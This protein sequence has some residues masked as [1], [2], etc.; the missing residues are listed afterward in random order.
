MSEL[1]CEV[2]KDLLPSYADGITDDKTSELVKE[3]LASC[4]PC[5]IALE[6][7]RENEEEPSEKET[8][9][10]DFLKKSRRKGIKIAVIAACCAALIALAAVLIKLFVIGR[11][12][13]YENLSVSIDV[14][15]KTLSVTGEAL[16]SNRAVSGIKFTEKDG[17]VAV[18]A[19]T[20]VKSLLHN[21]EAKGEYVSENTI[22]KVSVNGKTVYEN[23]EFTLTFSDEM[24]NAGKE[25]WEHY[26]SLPEIERMLMSTSPG[27]MSRYFGSWQEAAEY[28]GFEIAE[29]LAKVPGFVLRTYDHWLG[30]DETISAFLT[31]YCE[32]NGDVIY[33]S[34]T[35]YYDYGDLSVNFTAEPQCRQNAGTDGR[36]YIRQFSPYG[37][38][39]PDGVLT[40]RDSGPKYSAANVIFSVNGIR[41]CVRIIDNVRKDPAALEDAI[42]LVQSIAEEMMN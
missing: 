35:E 28:V 38:A 19:R 1:P 42:A 31:W 25:N 16:D 17:E 21:G 10:I 37:N 30:K 24:I 14:N 29:P 22:E 34:L 9:E 4:E 2:V 36:F 26:N 23:G 18:T 41:Y 32:E 39:D 13:R 6:A 40:E 7:M 5:R 3:H 27:F 20:V 8:A 15:E 12:A 11:D 33:A